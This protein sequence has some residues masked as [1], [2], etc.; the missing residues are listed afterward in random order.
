MAG[1]NR[2]IMASGRDRAREFALRNMASISEPY[3]DALLG[4]VSSLCC[5]A[6]LAEEWWAACTGSGRAAAPSLGREFTR[7]R[8]PGWRIASR[9]N[10]EK[11]KE[12]AASSPGHPPLGP[13]P[14]LLTTSSIPFLGNTWVFQER[15]S[16]VLQSFDFRARFGH[17][18]QFDDS[19]SVS[20]NLLG[21]NAEIITKKVNKPGENLPAWKRE[22]MCLWARPSIRMTTRVTMSH[23]LELGQLWVLECNVEAWIGHHS[24]GIP[25][26]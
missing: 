3:K 20:K 19:V 23:R 26:K 22:W 1:F 4:C 12:M 17:C 16:A 25:E 18:E 13:P 8:K 5:Q 6:L 11:T 14:L 21:A 9:K 24:A 7:Q 2:V 10:G 15:F